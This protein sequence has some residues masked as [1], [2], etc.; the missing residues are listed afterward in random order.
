M[1]VKSPLRY[2]GGKSRAVE[3]I[4]RYFPAGEQSLLA[5]FLGGGSV[6]LG[7]CLKGMRVY[8]YDAFEDLVVFWNWLQ[9]DPALLGKTV[10][11]YHPLSKERFYQLQKEIGTATGVQRAAMFFVLNRSSFSGSTLSGGMSP[12]HPRFNIPSIERLEAFSAP[13]LSVEHKDFEKS[14]AKHP[15]MLAYLDPP[16]WIKDNLYGVKGSM[17]R[18]FA[19]QKLFEIL[20]AREKWILSYNDCE[21]VRTLYKKY[22]ILEPNWSYGMGKEKKSKELLILSNDIVLPL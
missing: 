22:K 9:Q 5:P 7:A 17:H 14:L 10:R 15:T 11:T 20:D 1:Y 21:Q 16:Y 18:G 2:P 6:E 8:G 19:H 13:L 12:K 4:L 3:E